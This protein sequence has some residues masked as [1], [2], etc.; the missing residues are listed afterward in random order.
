MPR[1]SS[2]R[3]VIDASIAAAASDREETSVPKPHRDFLQ[4]A[5]KICHRVVMTP[6]LG[7]LRHTIRKPSGPD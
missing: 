2:T 6:A 7:K 4:R 3:L 5:R 1:R